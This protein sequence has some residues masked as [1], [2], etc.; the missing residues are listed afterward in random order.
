MLKQGRP[1]VTY[2]SV[3]LRLNTPRNRTRSTQSKSEWHSTKRKARRGFERILRTTD[4]R[5][6]RASATNRDTCHPDG[7]CS[8]WSAH[9]WS[10]R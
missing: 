10:L 2:P 8:D 4:Q 5:T 6:S 3:S 1:V 9:T 7:P